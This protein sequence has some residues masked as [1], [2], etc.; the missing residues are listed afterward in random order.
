MAQILFF[1]VWPGGSGFVFPPCLSSGQVTLGGF[2][3]RAW[4][5]TPLGGMLTSLDLT[6]HLHDIVQCHGWL[7]TTTDTCT[8]CESFPASGISPLHLTQLTEHC[9]LNKILQDG[10]GSAI[11]KKRSGQVRSLVWFLGSFWGVFCLFCLF[12]WLWFGVV[13]GLFLWVS[14]FFCLAVFVAFVGG[15]SR[16]SDQLGS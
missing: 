11:L 9:G 3:E 14:V 13:L 6:C 7:I 12:W 10:F 2:S 4:G 5:F 8:L 1:P 15:F 16:T